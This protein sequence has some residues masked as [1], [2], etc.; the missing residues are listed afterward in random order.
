M[1]PHSMTF[2]AFVLCL[3]P[4]KTYA[5]TVQN[6]FTLR[7]MGINAARSTVRGQTENLLDHCKLTSPPHK[8]S[9]NHKCGS[10]AIGPVIILLQAM[11]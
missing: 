9:Y 2:R 6:H 7:E 5:E 10:T 8:I 11:A 4:G 1:P 3:Q